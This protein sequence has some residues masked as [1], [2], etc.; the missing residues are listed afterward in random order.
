M[1]IEW[2]TGLSYT[3]VTIGSL[4]PA[5]AGNYVV[6]QQGSAGHTAIYAGESSN[7]RERFVDHDKKSCFEKQGATHISYRVNNSAESR[8]QEEKAIRDKYK[9]VCNSQ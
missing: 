7:I 4:L 1:T 5:E 6:S 8:R 2:L 9:P 3:A